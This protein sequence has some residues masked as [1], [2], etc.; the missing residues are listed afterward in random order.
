M[1]EVDIDPHKG[2]WLL[3]YKGKTMLVSPDD[4]EEMVGDY[5]EA[6]MWG[7]AEISDEYLEYFE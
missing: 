3:N 6:T 2:M 1:I 7:S 5:E 4:L